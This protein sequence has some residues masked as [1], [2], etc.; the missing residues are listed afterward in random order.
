MEKRST[1]V[2]VYPKI[3]GNVTIVKSPMVDVVRHIDNHKNTLCARDIWIISLNI[4]RSFIAH[5]LVN[6]GSGFMVHHLIT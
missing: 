4:D 3:I 6:A 2:S 5:H 1:L